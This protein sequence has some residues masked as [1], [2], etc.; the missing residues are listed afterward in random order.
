V[1]KKGGERGRG[2]T[3]QMEGVV[4]P[5]AS[6]FAPCLRVLLQDGQAV[7]LTI[8]DLDPAL[9]SMTRSP[10]RCSPYVTHLLS[11]L[12]PPLPLEF[13]GY[14]V[15][16][17]GSR[18]A[19]VSTS[20][21]LAL[22]GADGQPPDEFLLTFDTADHRTFLLTYK[23]GPLYAPNAMFNAWPY[24]KHSR[25]SVKEHKDFGVPRKFSSCLPYV[26]FQHER[27]HL[28]ETDVRTLTHECLGHFTLADITHA[29]AAPP[30][31]NT[32]SLTRGAALDAAAGPPLR[33]ALRFAR[34]ALG[35]PARL[36]ATAPRNPLY[37]DPGRYPPR[38]ARRARALRACTLYDLSCRIMIMLL[39]TSSVFSPACCAASNNVALT[40]TWLAAQMRAVHG[41][42]V[43]EFTYRKDPAI[44][45]RV[46]E[47]HDSA[48]AASAAAVAIP[49]KP[50]LAP[51][52][53]LAP[54]L[55]VSLADARATDA[56]LV[57]AKVA[58]L[59]VLAHPFAGALPVPSGAA[60]TNAALDAHLA[61]SV[62][63]P[64]QA[65]ARSGG[66]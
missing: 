43:A 13:S 60:L 41:F 32:G 33:T 12:P 29:A 52:P 20:G 64:R 28:F 45:P 56:A 17:A 30:L 50:A 63:T 24:L 23:V 15:Y 54:P 55:V 10:L 14:H 58:R 7:Q 25:P 40:E 26:C 47:T 46:T 65:I 59:A 16:A 38:L 3:R 19:V 22:I 37:A 66:G 36:L 34:H 42:G 4:C 48:A 1:R 53:S 18:T 27:R 35:A 62:V 9:R 2:K 51:A 61:R 49:A 44:F 8:T 6:C 21:D 31:L 57:G 39:T 11:A 5:W